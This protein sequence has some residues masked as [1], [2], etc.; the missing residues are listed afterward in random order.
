VYTPTTHE[1]RNHPASSPFGALNSCLTSHCHELQLLG[2]DPTGCVVQRTCALQL[3]P[4]PQAL[5]EAVVETVRGPGW[6]GLVRSDANAV[7]KAPA[8]KVC[9]YISYQLIS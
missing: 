1:W 5:L 4:V 9:R 6:D 7:V 2:G 3:K 8:R